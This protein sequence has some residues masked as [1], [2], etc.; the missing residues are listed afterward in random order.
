MVLMD[1]RTGYVK[2]LIGGRGEK[3]AS[4]TLN[5]AT[6]S[7]RQPGSTF[8]I[9]STY[10]Y[11]LD[12]GMKTLASTYL[13]DEITYEDGTPVSNS[14]NAYTHEMMN[15]RDAIINSVNTVAVQTITDITPKAAYNQL[16][17]YG[18]TTLSERNDVY[19]PLALGGIY[20][21]VTNLELT[22]AFAAI[23]NEGNYTKP[24][25]YTRIEDQD[26]NIV[27]NNTPETTRAISRET[28]AL[29]T[30]A[31]EDVVTKGTGQNVRLDCGMPVAGKTGTTTDYRDVWFV[32]FTPYYTCGVW[33]GYDDSENL[34]DEGI[35]HV[36]H[37]ILW[38]AVMDRISRN[39]SKIQFLLPNTITHVEV[40]SQTGLI[41]RGSCPSHWEYFAPGTA[42]T[43]TCGGW[44]AHSEYYEEEEEE[45]WNRW[46]YDWDEEE[47]E[48]TETSQQNQ[49]NQNN[50][51][52][53]ENH[54]DQG[55]NENQEGNNQ[56]TDENNN[57][58]GEEQSEDNGGGGND[59]DYDEDEGDY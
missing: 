33:A 53:Q 4:L 56:H 47:E 24:I 59:E 41:P 26:G 48:E 31:M 36:Y 19:Q 29:L 6:N 52:N 13:D 21:G 27:I 17:K 16:L 3:T 25:F 43:E 58:G 38:K 42:P 22:A 15:I 10:S 20:N 18:F 28:A 23:A 54:S 51:Q 34:P 30:S 7:T 55:N 1:Q 9:L 57:G 40:C 45:D 35:Y 39:Q 5:R 32:G 50:Q 8:K 46:D 14:N 12:S 37:Q 11:A 44:R 49:E 2:G